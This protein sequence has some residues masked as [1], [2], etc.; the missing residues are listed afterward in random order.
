M[1]NRFPVS[2]YFKKSLE[3]PRWVAVGLLLHGVLLAVACGDEHC[4]ALSDTGRL[5]AWGANKRGQLGVGHTDGVCAP[6]PVLLPTDLG[7][8]GGMGGLGADTRVAEVVCGAAFTL[9]GGL[10]MAGPG[11][12]GGRSG[13]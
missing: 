10:A 8:D 11:G 9:A 2:P 6:T 1:R 12:A 7:A 4:V 13:P 5:F 3:Q